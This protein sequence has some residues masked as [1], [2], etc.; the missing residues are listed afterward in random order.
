MRTT[1]H[2][3]ENDAYGRVSRLASNVAA[4]PTLA[5]SFLYQPATE[6]RYAWRFGNGTARTY[7][8][9]SDRRLTLLAGTSLHSLSYGWNTTDTLA[10]L[11]D[12]VYPALNAGFGYDANDRLA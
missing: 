8:H 2:C 9:D 1:T 11:T 4:W 12:N 10:S 3:S 7:T 5:D 6:Q